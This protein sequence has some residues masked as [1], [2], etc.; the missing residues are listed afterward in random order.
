MAFLSF[1]FVKIFRDDEFSYFDDRT[2]ADD[3]SPA[4]PAVAGKTR[5]LLDQNPRGFFGQPIFGIGHPLEAV[6]AVSDDL[7]DSHGKRRLLR[8]H[9]KP[10]KQ[11]IGV[12]EYWNNGF[13]ICQHSIT[14]ILHSPNLE[15][16]ETHSQPFAFRHADRFLFNR[17]AKERI[18]GD[19]L[20][21]PELAQRRNSWRARREMHRG[22]VTDHAAR[23]V[24]QRATNAVQ[25][26]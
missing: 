26:A 19:H 16:P 5:P 4:L 11:K 2:I 3:E 15:S 14:P 18:A 20:E 6:I 22:C 13:R 8:T 1:F 9:E 24:R 21:L 23:R 10:P 17:Q 12:V 25:L 7:V